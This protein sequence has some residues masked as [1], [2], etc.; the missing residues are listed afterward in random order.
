M[1]SKKVL[2]GFLGGVF[3]SSFVNVSSVSAQSSFDK[4]IEG[5]GGIKKGKVSN[6]SFSSKFNPNLDATVRRQFKS[7]I[8]SNYS[9]KS[10]SYLEVDIN[11]DGKKDAFVQINSSTGGGSGGFHTWV[12]QSTKNGYELISIFN[13]QVAL[14]ILS[15]KT[16]GWQEIL[17]VPGKIYVPNYGAYYYQCSYVSSKQWEGDGDFRS[18]NNYR[19]CRKIQPNSVVSGMVIDTSIV[20]KSYPEFDLAS[21]PSAR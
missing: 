2:L 8:S 18:P 19:N 3:A 12:F 11:N 9:N 5:V 14:V 16:S 20:G 13:H 7:L 4:A 15:T 1:N 10:Y 6:L 21:E 17:V